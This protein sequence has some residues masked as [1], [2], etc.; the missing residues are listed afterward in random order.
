MRSHKQ[1]QQFLD[2]NLHRFDLGVQYLGDEPNAYRKDWDS[3]SVRSLMLASWSYEACVGGDTVVLAEDAGPVRIQSLNTV[4]RVD[5]GGFLQASSSVIDSGVREV[6][7]VYAGGRSVVCTPDHR[8]LV[9]KP[10]KWRKHGPTRRE[11]RE[12]APEVWVEAKNLQPGDMF[13][14]FYGQNIW[15]AD[16]VRLPAVSGKVVSNSPIRFPHELT[17]D[18]AYLLGL[19]ATDSNIRWGH[20]AGM[21][22]AIRWSADDPGI[23]EALLE[24]IPEVFGKVPCV[25]RREGRN[26]VVELA[27]TP[28]VRWLRE[29]VGVTERRRVPD[30]IFASPQDVVEAYLSGIFDGDGCFSTSGR[31]MP[32]RPSL[33]NTERGLIEDVATLLL[34]R[35][36]PVSGSVRSAGTTPSRAI[37]DLSGF[38]PIH[39]LHARWSADMDWGWM[40]LRHSTRQRGLE[41]WKN[42]RPKYLRK[43]LAHEGVS[44]VEVVSVEPAGEERVWDLSV[45]DTE[46]FTANGIVVHNSAGNGSIPSVYKTINIARE[47]S[48]C[49]RFYLPATPR[50][51]R[52]L[53]KNG[54]PVFGIESKRALTEFDLVGTSIS[55][56]VL[57]MSF[58]KMLKMSGI[59]V[60]WK[61][62]DASHPFVIFG[63]QAYAAPEVLAPVVD[64]VFLGEVEDEPGNPGLGVVLD[65]IVEF[66][67]SGQWTQDRVGCYAALA[68]EFSFLY[69]PRFVEVEYGYQDRGMEHPSKQVIGHRSTLEGME[70]PFRRHYVKELDSIPPLDDP[71]LLYVD[72][73]NASGDAEVGRGS[74]AS[75]GSVLIEGQ[76]IRR[77]SSWRGD[78]LHPHDADLGVMRTDVAGELWPVSHVITSGHREVVRVSTV[79]GHEVVCTPDHEIS[80]VRGPL[81][82]ARRVRRGES[83]PEGAVQFYAKKNVGRLSVLES[84]DRVWARA[85]DVAVDDVIPVYYGQNIW[86][87]EQVALQSWAVHPWSVLQ[88]LPSVLD[89][90]VAWLLGMLA[91]DCT[92]S[93]KPNRPSFGHRLQIKTEDSG[94]AEKTVQVVE[95]LFGHQAVSYSRKNS[96]PQALVW[97]IRSKDL[98][99]W[100]AINFGVTD[101]VTR[102]RVPE[103]IMRSPRDVVASFV[104]GFYDSDGTFDD[105]NGRL[106][107]C[108]QSEE[109]IRDLSLILLNFGAPCSVVKQPPCGR[110]VK[111]TWRVQALQTSDSEWSWLHPSHTRRLPQVRQWQEWGSK[112]VGATARNGVMYC[113]VTGVVPAGSDDCYDISVPGPVSFTCN[114]MLV[115]NCPAWCSFPL[116]SE[117]TF[118]TSEGVLSVG[119]AVGSAFEV[120]TQ[121]GWAKGRVQSHG[122]QAVQ[123][124]EFL[125]GVVRSRTGKGKI[126]PS[127][128]THTVTVTATAHHG[129][130]LV[131]GAVTHDLQVGDVV[132]M[133]RVQEHDTSSVE[134]Q[135][136]L[137]HGWVFA[138]GS[139][140]KA[141]HRT[142]YALRLH[143]KKA[144][145]VGVFEQ[146]KAWDADKYGLTVVSVRYPEYTKGDPKIWIRSPGVAL[147]EFPEGCSPEYAAGFLTGWMGGDATPRWNTRAGERIVT[148]W[149]LYSQDDSAYE[150]LQTYAALAGWVLVGHQVYRNLVTNFGERSGVLRGYSLVKPESAIR[151]WVVTDIRPLAEPQEVFCLEVEDVHRFTLS[152]GIVTSNCRLSL[153]TKP[154]RQRS[155][156]YM[157]EFGKSLK[158]NMGGTHIAYVAPDFPF[159]SRKKTMTKALL[160]NVTD[161]VDGAAMRVDDFIEDEQ[162]VM[163]SSFG[164]MDSVTLGLEGS[165]QRMRDLVGKGISDVE[166]RETVTKALEAGVR[167][168]KLFMISNLPGEDWGDIKQVVRLAEDLAQIRDSMNKPHVVIQLS[169]TPLLIE[170]NTP[171]QWFAPTPANYALAD[172]WKELKD[173]RIEAKIGAKAQVDKV[174]FFQLCQRASREIGEAMVDTM[175]ELDVACW[176]GVPRRMRELLDENMRKW[177]FLNGLEDAFDERGKDDLFGWEFIDTGVSK[178]LLWSVYRQMVEFLE[179]TDSDT[180]DELVG[181]DYHGAEWVARCDERCQGTACGACDRKDLEIR[182]EMLANGEDDQGFS[183]GEIR[184]IDERSVA[185][186]IRA[187]VDKPVAYRLVTN[188]HWR[189]NL[190]RALYRAKDSID[191][192]A[193]IAKRTIVFASDAIGYKDWTHGTDYVEF[194]LTQQV[195][196]DLI[197]QFLEEVNKELVNP[198]TDQAWMQIGEWVVHP[199]TSPSIRTDLDLTLYEVEV[200]EI[201]EKIESQ[202]RK[203]EE[204][205][206]VD[207]TIRAPV[208]YFGP[209]T[210]VVNAKEYV[211]G[212]WMVKDGHRVTV[213]MLVRGRP[214]PYNVFAALMGQKSWLEVAKYPARRVDSFVS[215]DEDQQ[216][217]FRPTC[218][219]CGASIPVNVLEEPFDPEYCPRCKDSAGAY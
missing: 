213:R 83:P 182:Q 47:D 42:Y 168:I 102:R 119:A 48:L 36:C 71:P 55:Y 79:Q 68:R 40:R 21:S 155:P 2:A 27:S 178:D 63:G 128:T 194:G 81:F 146:A 198:A 193:N 28:L 66:K 54:I 219:S 26:P 166:V 170:A 118:I 110:G 204:A 18:L 15:A 25:V 165:S 61:D 122:V 75:G 179:Y 74:I 210:E 169:W 141:P 35:G 108:S 197:G 58:V 156:E 16:R 171:F 17:P 86:G 199:P 205:D 126:S 23:L 20:R 162:F 173:L 154:Y 117:E 196:Q 136:G 127:R 216:D 172:A 111:H 161:E 38:R 143:G 147:K 140:S 52:L 211:D 98:M 93:Y 149:V 142:G 208:T 134:Y 167:K 94:V 60:R 175:L 53:E 104:A 103:Q 180:Y 163:L 29:S 4:G 187:R 24:I 96:R 109:L 114:G 131:D 89:E 150:W 87:Q 207:M 73:Q 99:E 13:K 85:D 202:L 189:F 174:T 132:P 181:D 10:E 101:N 100:L 206:T 185:M 123:E 115:H 19:M 72:A 113:V 49:D 106:S 97:E 130:E 90:D 62:R 37:A 69:F 184:P 50:D 191:L 195:P 80:V 44:S 188:D 65:R 190:R 3:S 186:K 139:K 135:K 218:H 159:H 77:F 7:R 192:P 215:W 46:S 116:A 144:H 78:D 137:I 64:A 95:R 121:R 56:P 6:V 203:W 12:R 67:A 92:V 51:M 152:S 214:T 43:C 153:V 70:M 201:P 1:I 120:W 82:D 183:L 9:T 125:P 32:G 138:D 11:L 133:T 212:I 217:F 14:V 112:V 30:V 59:P 158:R 145:A 176:G 5:C 160:E 45:P 84:Q 57:T 124:V 31:Y 209:P 148:S 129:W 34:N 22:S 105:R 177:G 33:S 8:F 157:V 88:R 41:A 164:G 39:A 107:W 151:G 91:G 76:G 200:E